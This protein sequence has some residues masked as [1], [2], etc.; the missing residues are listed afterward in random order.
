MLEHTRQL[1][2]PHFLRRHRHRSATSYRCLHINS[3]LM[4]DS[5]VIRHPVQIIFR[6]LF[7]TPKIFSWKHINYGKNN[8]RKKFA[9]KWECAYE[10]A[11]VDSASPSKRHREDRQ[12]SIY[13]HQRF[14]SFFAFFANCSRDCRERRSLIIYLVSNH[15]DN[16][17]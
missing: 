6:H 13:N 17:I 16:F 3:V 9:Y 15:F 12:T 2:F 8:S 1:H 11:D 4:H 7:A 5:R 14:Y 10:I